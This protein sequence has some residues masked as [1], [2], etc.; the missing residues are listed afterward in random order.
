MTVILTW[1]IALFTWMPS[2]VLILLGF[3]WLSFQAYET[4]VQSLVDSVIGSVNSM[5]GVVYAI[6]SL[7]GFIDGVGVI[8]AAIVVRASFV[9][10]DKL[11]RLGQ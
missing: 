7:A 1:L 6:A 10:L 11:A 5:P 3:G 9:F 2:R 4:A 8:L